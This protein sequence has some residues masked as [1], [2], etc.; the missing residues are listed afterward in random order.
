MSSTQHIAPGGSDATT[1]DGAS[2]TSTKAA[3][4]RIARLKTFGRLRRRA[5]WLF[6]LAPVLV[7]LGSDVLTRGHDLARMPSRYWFVYLVAVFESAVLWGTLLWVTSARRGAVRWIAAFVFALLMSLAI[8]VQHY[9][10]EQYATYLNLDATLFGTSVADSALGQL[11]ADGRFFLRSIGIPMLLALVMV[12]AARRLIRPRKRSL[13]VAQLIAPVLVVAVFLIPCSYQRVQASTPDVIYFHAM[14]GLIKALGGPRTP[15]QVKP[16]R[17]HP[18]AMQAMTPSPSRPRNV[19]MILTESVRADAHCS[20]YDPECKNS[21]RVNEALPDRMPLLQLRS[22]SSTTA[23]EL[24]VLWSGLQPVESREKLHTAPLLYDYAHAAGLESAYWT[25][26]HMMFANSRLFVQDLPTRFQCGGSDVDP[27]ADLDLGGADEKLVAR[28]ESEMPQLKEPFFAVVHVGNTHVPYRPDP[29]DSP[30]Q[31]SVASKDPDSN[32]AYHNYYRNAVYNQDKALGE[33][34]RFIRKSA[35]SDRT[36]IFFTSDHAESFREHNQTGHTGS[37]FDEEIHVP[38]WIDAPPGTLTESE[39]LAIESRRDKATFHTDVTPTILD[40]LGLL[41][42]P[43]LATY[44]RDMVGQSWIRPLDESKPPT[45]LAMTN[46]SGVWG[47]AFKNWGMMRGF[48]KL[49]GREW[50]DQW[51]CYDVAADPFEKHDLGP[52]GCADLP[53]LAEKIHGG[54]PGGQ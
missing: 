5:G 50:D 47:C 3:L 2:L 20:A 48:L 23:I 8:G 45:T 30:Y 46:C 25:S 52:E 33:M 22:N 26:H 18:P 38:G 10:H 34:V 41:D 51:R 13:R 29:N 36:V 21:P 16:G 35:F 39:R 19:V 15:Q 7:V 17:R 11:S 27:V 53:A 4:G 32:D 37:I 12:Y 14:G 43:Q 6:V 1:A 24:A 44:K 9:F 42:A 31:P 54:F 28:A 40:L 49:E